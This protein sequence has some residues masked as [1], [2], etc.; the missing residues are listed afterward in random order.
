MNAA[1]CHSSCIYQCIEKKYTSLTPERIFRTA[2][3]NEQVGPN[4]QQFLLEIVYRLE[5]KLSSVVT[6]LLAAI[7]CSTKMSGVKAIQWYHL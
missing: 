3:V 5:Q 6:G 1:N 4:T 2:H 7:R